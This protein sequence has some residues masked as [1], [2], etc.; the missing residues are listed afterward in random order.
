M[1]NNLLTKSSNAV[2]FQNNK[3]QGFVFSAFHS[4]HGQK[5]MS[6]V[7]L[8][9][10]RHLLRLWGF[11]KTPVSP[12]PQKP[13]NVLFCFV[14]LSMLQIQA[15][16]RCHKL[17]SAYL[18]AVKLEN[19]RAVQLVQHVRQLAEDSGEDVVQAIC[20]QWLSLHQAKPKSWLAQSTKKWLLAE[21]KIF[22]L[23]KEH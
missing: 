1:K 11:S 18:V 8:W 13:A 14:F 7:H 21:W 5:C 19:P 12:Y 4:W 22:H 16:L 2:S 23:W 9:A 10:C 17:R 3:H 6:V 15:Y 20:T